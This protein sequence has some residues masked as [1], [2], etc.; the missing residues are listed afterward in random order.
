MVGYVDLKTQ[1]NVLKV[2]SH[3][4]LKACYPFL[5][6]IGL[7]AML[8]PPDTSAPSKTKQKGGKTLL[9]VGKSN[10]E[11]TVHIKNLILLYIKV[12]DCFFF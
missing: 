1:K 6:Y 8:I 5:T 4:S 7:F 3:H 10:L 2:L 11:N 9:L 12:V